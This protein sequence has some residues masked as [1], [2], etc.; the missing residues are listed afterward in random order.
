[1]K[2]TGKI[3]SIFECFIVCALIHTRF[4]WAMWDL[5][6]T[7]HNYPNSNIHFRMWAC[8]QREIHLNIKKTTTQTIRHIHIRIKY[9]MEKTA[10]QCKPTNA[11]QQNVIH[12][13]VHTCS[14]YVYIKWIWQYDSEKQFVVQDTKITENDE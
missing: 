9:I 12:T 8:I 7:S 10:K 3:S 5:H 2:N 1:M 4:I 6:H 11:H 14:V 13:T